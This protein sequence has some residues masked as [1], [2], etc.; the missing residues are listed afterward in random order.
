MTAASRPSPSRVHSSR[1]LMYVLMMFVV[2][3]TLLSM[4]MLDI[5]PF[6]NEHLPKYH[7]R[8]EA[9]AST[10][11]KTKSRGI[12]ICLFDAMIPMTV[13]LIQELRTL[14]YTDVIQLYHCNGEL[15]SISERMLHD[16][17]SNIEIVDG[18]VEMQ[19]L[20]KLRHQDVNG[21]RSFWLKP[22][23]LVH[24]RLD[25][26]ILMDADD[27][28]FQNPSRLFD[29]P[30]Y[31]DTGTIFF[32]DREILK[33]EYLNG[34]YNDQSELF[35]IAYELAQE[36]YFFSPWAN[37]GAEKPGNMA[38]HPDTICG[39]VHDEYLQEFYFN[40]YAMINL[41]VYIFNPY[42]NNDMQSMTDPDE[43][44]KQLLDQVPAFVSKRRT[45]SKA[46]NKAED[47]TDPLGFWPQE[48]LVNRGSEPM[49]PQDVAAIRIRIKKAVA[50]AVTQQ[51]LLQQAT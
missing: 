24:T 50:A 11:I 51:R 4:T 12:L 35:W 29:V 5:S 36:P 10:G 27:L 42:S 8:A 39:T 45:R 44:A 7:I 37:T 31:K 23:A 30:G 19:A 16:I 48:C 13:S 18:C 17:D 9:V 21:Y 40:V 46:L 2:S 32:Y 20:G 15:S 47:D 34:N 28:V 26:V 49:R 22:L 14:G 43:R 33:H 6:M 38:N 3:A 41:C 1:S 25:E